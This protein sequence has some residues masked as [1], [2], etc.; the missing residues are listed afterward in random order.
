MS[1]L[2]YILLFISYLLGSIPFGLLISKMYGID[3]RLHGSKNIG[4]TNVY[5]ILGKKLGLFTFFLDGLKG[6]LPTFLFPIII[7]INDLDISALF[8][9]TAIIGHSFSVF[10]KFKGG[11]GVATSTGMIIGV[12]PFI[13]FI[14]LLVWIILFLIFRY[15]S[16]ASIFGILTITICS[17]LNNQ[18]SLYLNI[19]ISLIS[20]L[21]IFLH[22]ENIIRLINGTENKFSK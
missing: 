1:S 9:V 15:V 8:G 6:F 7:G 10:L 11:K 19:L 5:R 13:F 16:L 4:A 2:F 3:I 20:I 17:W 18:S 22:R 21:I 12:L 14:G